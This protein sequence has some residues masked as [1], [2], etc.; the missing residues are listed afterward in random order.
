MANNEL[1]NALEVFKA[2]GKF[3]EWLACIVRIYEKDGDMKATKE[4]LADFRRN[5]LASTQ[6]RRKRDPGGGLSCRLSACLPWVRGA[7]FLLRHPH[8]T[9]GT[10]V[11]PSRVS[12]A[13]VLG[14]ETGVGG[15]ESR[16]F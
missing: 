1:L 3:E 12:P 4:R 7:C 10:P 13:W 11:L 16:Y 6:A 2:N 8:G 9:S 14:G 5:L 15:W